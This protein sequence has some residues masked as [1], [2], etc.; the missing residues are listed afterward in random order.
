MSLPLP[1]SNTKV[2]ECS[3]LGSTPKICSWSYKWEWSQNRLIEDL[4][5]TL[6]NIN[7]K[8]TKPCLSLHVKHSDIFYYFNLFNCYLKLIWFITPS[9]GDNTQYEKHWTFSMPRVSRRKRILLWVSGEA[10][11]PVHTGTDNQRS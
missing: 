1:R 6:H 9:M 8:F 10:P 7:K 3:V 4:Y 2:Q 11:Y 5:I